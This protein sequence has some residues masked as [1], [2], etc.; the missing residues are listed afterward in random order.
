MRGGSAV[1]SLFSAQQSRDRE[2][3]D[4]AKD[5]REVRAVTEVRYSRNYRFLGEIS[6]RGRCMM[7][8]GEG[9]V[10]MRYEVGGKR[11][12]GSASVL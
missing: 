4:R 10:V 12:V 6:S 3:R 7:K 8:V 2:R 9:A 5:A 1:S 11:A